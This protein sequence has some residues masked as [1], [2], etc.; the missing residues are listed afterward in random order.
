MEKR[1]KD[2]G[3]VRWNS[4][5]GRVDGHIRRVRVRDFGWKGHA[6]HCS[7]DDPQ[8]EIESDRTGHVAMHKGSALER[9]RR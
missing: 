1:F 6:R 2:G 7:A 8:H 9:L 5:A 3:H 4:L